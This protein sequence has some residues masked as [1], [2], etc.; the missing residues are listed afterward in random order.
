MHHYY[1]QELR[2]LRELGAEFARKFPEVAGRLGLGELS[3]HDPHVERVFQGF[4]LLAGRIQQRLGA[5]FPAFTETL[6]D[7]VYGHLFKPTPSM[8]VVQFKPSASSSSLKG[9]FTVPRNTE[10]RARNAMTRSVCR[11]TTA[12]AVELW[13]LAIERIE[14]TSV[15]HSI[16]DMRVPTREPIQALLRIGLRLRSGQAFNELPLKSLP[17]YVSGTDE[18]SARLYEAMVAHAGMLVLRWGKPPI[19]HSALG[20]V[21]PATR[22]LGLRADEALLPPATPEFEGHRLLQEYFNFVKRF[23]FVELRGLGPGVTRCRSD[24]LELI[25]PLKR[26]DP[27]LEGELAVDRLQLFATPA[28]NLFARRCDIEAVRGSAREFK[29]LVDRTQPRDFE[30]HSVTRVAALTSADAAQREYRP[31]RVVHGRLEREHAAP[32]YTVERRPRQDA[33]GADHA[34]SRSAYVGTDVFVQVSEPSRMS[35]ARRLAIDA[36]CTNRDV[37]LLLSRDRTSAFTLT[38]GAPVESIRCLEGPSAPRCAMVEGD[39]AW[40]LISHLRPNYL[41]VG[42]DT[43]RGEALRELLALFARFGDPVLRREVEGIRAVSSKPV[44]GPFPQPGPQ[45]FVRGLEI[46]LQCEEQIFAHGALKLA[47]VLSVV[48]AKQA[49][50]H[51]F[52]Q[53]ILD[54]VERGEVYRLPARPGLR[55]TL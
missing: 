38:S 5:E 46:R 21:S 49:G 7:D 37:P 8:A 53:T 29:V 19:R 32:H 34:S 14:Y 35:N 31:L 36:R 41:S 6:L 1:E 47:S 24:R 16:S 13:P 12:H 25:L 30:V 33:Y 3:N 27:L 44:I 51:S 40:R 17:L 20:E 22:Q 42:R 45:T 54:S 55:H 52:T 39:A 48:F 9:G 11:F 50:T 26:F 4:A 23:H 28:V 10:I 18:V 15:M 43:D 2:F